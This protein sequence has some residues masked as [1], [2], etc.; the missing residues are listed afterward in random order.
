MSPNIAI[1][2]KKIERSE[3]GNCCS[4]FA[5]AACRFGALFPKCGASAHDHANCPYS[6]SK[7]FTIPIYEARK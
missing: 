7:N 1:I 5:S 6:S 3:S 4:E 2:A